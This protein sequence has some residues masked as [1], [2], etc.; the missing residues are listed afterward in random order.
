MLVFNQFFSL[1]NVPWT[2]FHFKVVNSSLF[3][4]LLSSDIILTENILFYDK[5]NL[6]M[7]PCDEGMMIMSTVSRF[8]LP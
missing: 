4:K 5:T 7:N 6:V 1:A 3:Q 2:S 8:F